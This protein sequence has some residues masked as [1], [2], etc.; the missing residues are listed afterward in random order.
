MGDFTSHPEGKAADQGWWE[1]VS[2]LQAKYQLAS[3]LLE[4][5][6]V[7]VVLLSFAGGVL[8]AK[9][10][11]GIAAGV[12]SGV[13]GFV[14]LY[15]LLAP[16]IIFVILAPSLSRVANSTHGRERKFFIHAIAWMSIRRLISLFWAVVFTTVAFGFPLWSRQ[17]TDLG[18]SATK[19]ERLPTRG[20]GSW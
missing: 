12:N 6:L 13:E 3:K 2:K 16:I 18:H 11:P 8:V 17:G 20:G 9:E 1:L 4:K 19:G 14:D 7:P 5:Y 15:G 10:L